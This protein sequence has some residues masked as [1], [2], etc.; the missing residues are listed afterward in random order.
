MCKAG[1]A[2]TAYFYCDFKDNYKQS[3]LDM[4]PSLLTQL[5]ARSD[6]CRDILSRL[7]STYNHGAQMPTCSVLTE[8]LKEMLSQLGQNPVYIIIDAIDECPDVPGVPSSREDI[9]ELMKELVGLRLPNLRLCVTSR[10]EIDI[11]AVLEPLLSHRVSLHDESGQ[12]KD[13]VDYVSAVMCSDREFERWRDEDKHLVIKT[14]SEKAGG[15]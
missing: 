7:F 1:L 2:S 12:K 6:R 15:M 11:R 8:C 5:S 9:L 3:R 14:L 13:I 4:I 10:P